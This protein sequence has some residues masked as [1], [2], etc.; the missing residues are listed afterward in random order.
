[1]HVGGRE[2]GS[3]TFCLEGDRICILSLNF[4]SPPKEPTNMLDLRALLWLE[5]YLQVRFCGR[6]CYG[7][8]N[9]LL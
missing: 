7:K 3:C 9:P 1:M 4:A 8:V 5:E 2:G 6:D